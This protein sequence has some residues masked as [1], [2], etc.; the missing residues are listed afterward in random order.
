[1]RRCSWSL[2]VC[3][4]TVLSFPYLIDSAHSELV[5]PCRS[6]PGHLGR[7]QRRVHAWQVHPPRRI[8]NHARDVRSEIYTDMQRYSL[9]WQ[10]KFLLNRVSAAVLFAQYR[11]LTEAPNRTSF[12][13]L[14]PPV[15]HEQLLILNDRIKQHWA[16]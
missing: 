5:R 1:M 10:S 13:S 8:W 15:E 3:L 2:P 4:T 14:D 7:H 9:M 11:A 12:A 16:L 6:Q